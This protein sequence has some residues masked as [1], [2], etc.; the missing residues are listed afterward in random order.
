M[1]DVNEIVREMIVLLQ[2]EATRQ[3]ISVGPDLAGDLPALMGD[4][5]QLQQV[6]MNLI[7]NSIDAMKNVDGARE[8]A[9]NSRLMENEDILVSVSDT[10]VGLAPAARGSDFQ[11]IL[12]HQASRHRHGP[13]DQRNHCRIARRPLV[14]GDNSPRGAKFLF[15]LP[16]KIELHE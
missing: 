2:G 14:G 8:L 10:G 3:N 4:R 7:M 6:M 9:I 16:T 15:T 11:C 1:V 12:Y 13:A 5:V